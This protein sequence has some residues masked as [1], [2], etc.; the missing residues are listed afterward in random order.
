MDSLLRSQLSLMPVLIQPRRGDYV[1]SPAATGFFYKAR[2]GYFLVTNRHVVTGRNNNT[3]EPLCKKTSALPDNLLIKRQHFNIS[4]VQLPNEHQPRL[5]ASDIQI[6]ERRIDLF[7]GSDTPVWFEHPK[8]G[9][10]CDF[11][12][13]AFCGEGE[14][15]GFAV[16]E[17][18][19]QGNIALHPS[20][21]VS[22]I[23]FPFGITVESIFPIWVSG[24]LASEPNLDPEDLPIMYI[25]SRT[26]KGN[27]GSPVFAVRT[28][29]IV[30]IEGATQQH[31]LCDS[32]VVRFLGIYS[33]RVNENSDIGVVWKE[34]A[35]DFAK[36]AEITSD[37]PS[38]R[39][40]VRINQ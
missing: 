11:A 19:L 20:D 6:E 35:F 40:I 12:F 29:G 39:L 17:A 14:L 36:K 1:I 34:K 21:Q 25:D 23:G 9:P 33:G 24:F 16:N 8:F 32:P 26:R 5:S 18:E 7:D 4:T 10:Q 27:S 2:K 31:R 30:Q 15:N 22:V 3:D 37:K 13:I 28:H 38:G